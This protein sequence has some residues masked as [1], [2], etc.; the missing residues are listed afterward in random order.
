MQVEIVLE[1]RLGRRTNPETLRGHL[2]EISTI[3]LRNSKY[4]TGTVTHLTDPRQEDGIWIFNATINYRSTKDDPKVNDSFGKIIAG[5]DRACNRGKYCSGGENPWTIIKPHEWTREGR[6]EQAAVEVQAAASRPLGEVNLEVTDQFN[7]IYDRTSH[8]QLIMDAV[9]LAVETNYH[10]RV[11]TLLHGQAGCGKTE[12][13]T[14]LAKVLGEENQAYIKVD[15][16]TMTRAGVIEQLMESPTIPPFLF[17]EEIEKVEENML[18]WLLGIMDDRGEIRRLNY[19]TGAQQR[20]ARL[21]VIATANDKQLLKRFMSGALE[22]RFQNK[23][24]CKPPDRE[25]MKRILERE[26]L[27]IEGKLE[28]IE[29]TLKFMVD[30]LK[31][32]DPR[33]VISACL[34]GRDRLL[35]DSFQEDKMNTLDP[36][37]DGNNILQAIDKQLGKK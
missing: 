29:P 9:R 26:V 1:R 18:R 31:K 10:K 23:I 11:H 37:E 21:V 36:E 34:L 19:R 6:R 13:M 3:S 15:A 17:I 20:D 28:W 22:S 24:Y 14:S 8:I 7:H 4:W 2:R 27:E 5:L 33:E 25:T 35:D 30:V 32:T 12:I 16:T